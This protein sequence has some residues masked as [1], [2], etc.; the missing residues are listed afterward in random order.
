[1]YGR[2]GVGAGFVVNG[3]LFRGSGAGAGEIGHTTMIPEGGVK[4]Q[5]GNRGCLETLIS[6]TVLIHKANVLAKTNPA[7]ILNKH[8]KNPNSRR[9]IECIFDA[10]REG[11]QATRELI[12]E[13]AYYLGTALANLVNI[14]N[15]K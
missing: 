10:A 3:H 15:P 8:L 13:Q 6:E 9:V 1:V 14:L 11:D 7:S 5:C 12:Q 2:I 4:C